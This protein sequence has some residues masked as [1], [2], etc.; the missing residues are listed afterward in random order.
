M[1][2][3]METLIKAKYYSSK[4]EAIEIVSTFYATKMLTNEEYSKL[5][6]LINECYSEEIVNEGI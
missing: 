2:N 3:T 5:M 4:E 6:V 1:Y